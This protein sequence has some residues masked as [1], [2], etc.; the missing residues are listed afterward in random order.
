MHWLEYVHD[1]CTYANLTFIYF[2]LNDGEQ[3]WQAQQSIID[4][5]I[6]FHGFFFPVRSFVLYVYVY[7]RAYNRQYICLVENHIFI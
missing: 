6:D 7:V 1:S 3:F 5:F 2:A 4:K